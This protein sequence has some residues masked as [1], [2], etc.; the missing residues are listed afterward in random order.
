MC[1]R[2]F[3]TC[4]LPSHT[5]Q[6]IPQQW[7]GGSL[8][9]RRLEAAFVF[10]WPCIKH[11]KLHSLNHFQKATRSKSPGNAFFPLPPQKRACS[12]RA[13]PSLRQILRSQDVKRY[14]R[15]A[16]SFPH[17]RASSKMLSVH[18]PGIQGCCTSEIHPPEQTHR[19]KRFH[20]PEQNW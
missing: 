1:L 3:S 17:S 2:M 18:P 12:S 5:P 6:W 10:E 8:S 9:L 4:C 11:S 7:A 13:A 14:S 16:L 19:T 20:P 15:N